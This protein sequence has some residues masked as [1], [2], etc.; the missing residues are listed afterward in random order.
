MAT[1][2][3][4][5]GGRDN[6]H[7]GRIHSVLD[8]IV[9]TVRVLEG[10]PYVSIATGGALG[11]DAIAASWARRCGVMHVE[12]PA[13][14]DTYGKAAGPIRNRQMLR[15]FKPRLVVAFPG[16][17]GTADMV[18]AAREAGVPVVEVP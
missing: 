5:C 14:W 18:G 13:D 3:I 8:G 15:E 2:I 17:D 7:W 6:T 1:R 10:D 4:V 9:A 16:G 12:F 11:A